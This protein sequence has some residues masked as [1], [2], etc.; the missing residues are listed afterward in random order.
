VKALPKTGQGV[1]THTNQQAA[2]LL[3]AGGLVV[4]IALAS[5][6]RRRR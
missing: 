4:A 2:W 6:V 1:V 5:A 3:L